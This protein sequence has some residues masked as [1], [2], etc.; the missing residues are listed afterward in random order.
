VRI[1]R[2]VPMSCM[3]RSKLDGRGACRL[4]TAWAFRGSTTRQ[5]PGRGVHS[6][7]PATASFHKW[8][9]EALVVR[10]ART[11]AAAP[12]DDWSEERERRAVAWCP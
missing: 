9:P 6:L 11:L 2:E 1:F 3:L 7:G 10:R 4:P 8:V 12:N 5:K